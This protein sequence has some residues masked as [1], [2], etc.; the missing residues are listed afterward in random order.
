MIIISDTSVIS[1]LLQAKHLY[2]LRKLYGSIIIP[3]CVFNELQNLGSSFHRELAV[4]WIDVKD[5]TNSSLLH[6]LTEVLD[7]GEAEAVVLAIELRADFL[8]ID[9]KMGRAVASRMGLKITG[10]LGTL[11]EAKKQG[12]LIS[13]RPIIEVLVSKVG[14]R[15]K[16]DLIEEVLKIVNE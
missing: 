10:I 6:E 4:D 7:R 15:I 13:I 16:K 11:I 1:G 12:Y 3:K 8:L 5:V 2:L 14:V 9:E